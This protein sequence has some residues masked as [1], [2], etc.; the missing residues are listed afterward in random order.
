MTIK[1]Q[2]HVESMARAG[3]GVRLTVKADSRYCERPFEI[4]A[5]HGETGAYK[6]GMP[7]EFTVIPRPE[8]EAPEFRAD[9]RQQLAF[10]IDKV[11]GYLNF[12]MGNQVS[13]EDLERA[14]S[15]LGVESK[16][17]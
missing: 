1:F 6:V 14:L 8:A 12:R 15:V 10:L 2:G 3:N 11:T 9:A 7:V 16:R 4:D 13:R 5:S 17:R